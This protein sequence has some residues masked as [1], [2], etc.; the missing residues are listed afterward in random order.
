MRLEADV[1]LDFKDVLIRPKR[2][3]L[4]TRSEVDISR[5]FTFRH[6]K[7]QYHGIPIVAAIRYAHKLSGHPVP[8]DDERV[9][10]T[11]RG[12]RR[13]L[14]TAPQKKAPATA[15]RIADGRAT[16]EH[17]RRVAA[18][19]PTAPEGVAASWA[20]EAVHYLSRDDFHLTLEC[21]AR[22]VAAS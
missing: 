16:R 10:A 3:T 12:I 20:W 7:V 17:L 18:G 22:A 14:G 9:K 19:S 4:S 2:S 6:A 11:M 8:T 15:E 5:E 1:K 21:A 13:S